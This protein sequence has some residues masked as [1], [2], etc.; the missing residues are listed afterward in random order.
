MSIDRFKMESKD[1]LAIGD[2]EFDNDG[3]KV[4]SLDELEVGNWLS[5][6][7]DLTRQNLGEPMQIKLIGGTLDLRNLP[8]SRSS[9]T[10]A[11]IIADLDNLRISD[12]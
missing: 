7:V 10:T 4:A 1:F 12:D 2:M 8:L 6:N 5:S 9:G 3:L 11:P